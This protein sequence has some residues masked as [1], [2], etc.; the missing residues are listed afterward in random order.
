METTP[1]EKARAHAESARKLIDA[2]E[3]VADFGEDAFAD[4][5][6]D[7]NAI[8]NL[9]APLA[10][11]PTDEHHYPDGSYDVDWA[12]PPTDDDREALIGRVEGVKALLGEVY[13]TGITLLS[14]DF[15]PAYETLEDAVRALRRPLP[16]TDEW[17]YAWEADEKVRATLSP[18]GPRIMLD[19]QPETPE[20]IAAFPKGR[21]IRRRKAGPWEPVEAA[22]D[23]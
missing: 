20:R 3:E 14:I 19:D 5:K 16:I 2:L 12:T 7:V 8:F 13:H 18:R 9:L 21:R 22:R 4:L 10:D 23:A 17:E 6:Q 11:T 15:D 1:L